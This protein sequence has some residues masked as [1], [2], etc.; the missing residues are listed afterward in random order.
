MV[1]LCDFVFLYSCSKAKHDALT[2]HLSLLL[3]CNISIEMLESSNFV[4]VVKHV[5]DGVLVGE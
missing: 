4:E 5:G 2:S 3:R 1:V